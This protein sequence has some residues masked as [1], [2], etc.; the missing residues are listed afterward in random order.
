MIIGNPHLHFRVIGSTNDRA[1]QAAAEGA[2]G[3]MLVTAEEQS[4]GRGRQGRPWSTPPRSAVA[5]SVLIRDSIEV[6]GTLPLQVGVGVCEAVEALGV[7]EARMKWPNDIWIDLRKCAGILVEARPQD[8][9]AVAGVGLNLT[10]PDEE[11][12][13]EIRGR[14]TSVGRGV[15]FAE[16]VAALNLHVGQRLQAP[17]EETLTEFARRDALKGRRVS[18]E[19]GEGTAAGID[20]Q[21]NLLVESAAGCLATL[22]AGEVHLA[23]PADA[24]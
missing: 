8:G 10:I 19:Q 11:F 13:E 7:P 3:G 9:W 4:S 16:A 12:P 15:T 5:W 20:R 18:W 2:P 23:L 17:V 14:A 6:P 22:N 24:A 1:R 21:G